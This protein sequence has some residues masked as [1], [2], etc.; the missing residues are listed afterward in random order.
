MA[1]PEALEKMRR[2]IREIADSDLTEL[3]A[4][5]TLDDLGL[6]SLDRLELLVLIEEHYGLY[7]PDEFLAAPTVADIARGIS[8]SRAM[9][10]RVR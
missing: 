1:V 8:D 5:A 7:L 3:S 4:D 10:G 2:L 9:A 6:D